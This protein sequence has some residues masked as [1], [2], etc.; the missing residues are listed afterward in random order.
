MVQIPLMALGR[1]VRQFERDEIGIAELQASVDANGSAVDGAS[2]ALLAAVRQVSADLEHIQHAVRLDQQRSA[3]IEV[4]AAL[5]RELEREQAFPRREI[6]SGT[7]VA[8]VDRDWEADAA[9]IYLAD[10]IAHGTVERS[11]PCGPVVLDFDRLG[12]L[13]GI[14]VSAASQILLPHLGE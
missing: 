12:R 4:L 8:Y 14:E 7:P 10:V 13:V 6:P 3:A 9:Y 5:L 2:T 1:A 11:V